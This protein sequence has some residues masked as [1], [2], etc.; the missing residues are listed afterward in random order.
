MNTATRRLEVVSADLPDPPYPADTRA[1]G[2]R[3]ELAYEQ[4]EQSTTWKLAPSEL[5]P[6]LLMLWYR[7]WQE[8][9][10]G[11][12]PDDDAVIAATIGMQLT[13]FQTHRASL[14]RG[15]VKHSDGRLYHDTVG[16]RVLEMLE[17]RR[18]DA[19]RQAGQRQRKQGHGAP[20]RARNVGVTR[21][22][23][24]NPTPVPVPTTEDNPP[25]SPPDGGAS[26]PRKRRNRK[27]EGITFREWIEQCKA[28]GEQP[29]PQDDPVRRFGRDAKIPDPF[30]GLAWQWFRRKYRGRGDRYL[31]WRQHF[32]NAVE[33]NWH[34][35]WYLGDG[36]AGYA[37]TTKGV[38]LE[39]VVAEEKK[40]GADGA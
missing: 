4:I 7:S 6:W 22:S 16:A 23:T 5:R 34:R 31:D 30:M 1:K 11:S 12:L 27:T 38:Q 9:P 21:D 19:D 25:L 33:G 37:L 13:T 17:R 3:F 35:L 40:G 29:I 24:V 2:W 20:S 18:K 15:W 14:M 26:P 28:A 8:W 39:R 10:A 32:R 36:D